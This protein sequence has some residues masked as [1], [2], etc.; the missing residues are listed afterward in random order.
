MESVKSSVQKK[1]GLVVLVFTVAVFLAQVSSRWARNAPLFRL[2]DIFTLFS[3]VF[4][5]VCLFVETACTKRIQVLFLVVLGFA[6]LAS[7]NMF[8]ASCI[9]CIAFVLSYYYGFF[10]TQQWTKFF[11]LVPVGFLAF[12]LCTEGPILVRIVNAIFFMAIIYTFILI[13]YYVFLD[14]FRKCRA[15]EEHLKAEVEEEK[16]RAITKAV[17]EYRKNLSLLVEAFE[18]LLL[19][20]DK[21]RERDHE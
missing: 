2:L 11:L 21:K 16:E 14:M 4:S 18:R 3:I 13:V 19:I 5:S 1:T 17:S 15:Y 6:V 12:I 7:A 8:F 20:V 9:L 10:R